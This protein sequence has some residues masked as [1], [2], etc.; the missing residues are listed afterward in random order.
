MKK[1]V[2]Y[3]MLAAVLAAVVVMPAHSQTG[4]N[5][6]SE[7]RL[8]RILAS[9]GATGKTF[10]FSTEPV[11]KVQMSAVNPK[12]VVLPNSPQELRALIFENYTPQGVSPKRAMSAERL[13]GAAT[14]QLPSDSPAE[15]TAE[16]T[17]PKHTPP[18]QGVEKEAQ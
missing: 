7:A 13:V 16:T 3:T 2:I 4:E 6:V 9:D 14:E 5:G 8:R 18:T 17:P 12:S 1:Q 15:E 10:Q 11:A